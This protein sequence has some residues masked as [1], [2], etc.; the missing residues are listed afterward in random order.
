ML[1]AFDYP[2]FDF[3][4]C[5]DM[6][7][8]TPV[9]HPV[10]IVG[11]GPVGMAAAMDFAARGRKVL[12]L[13]DDKTVSVGS[14]AICFAKRTL[15]IMD[16]LGVGDAL[17]DKGIVWKI[18]KVFFGTDQ[19]YQFDLLPEDGHRMPAFI[20]LQQYHFEKAETDWLHAHPNVEIRWQNR[21]TNVTDHGHEVLVDIETPAGPYRIRADWVLAADG[22]RSAIRKM[23]DLDFHG[24]VFKDRFLIAD[25][26]MKADFP[27]ERWFWF[28]PP[29]NPGQSALL[30]MQADNVWRIDLQLGWDA[31]PEAE[32]QPGRVIPRLKRMLG[33]EVE[34]ELEWV[35]VYTFQ[36][37]RLDRFRHGRVLFVGDAAHQVSPF[38]ARGANSGIQDADNLVWKLDLVMQGVAGEA[39]LDSYDVERVIA[40]DENILNSTRS[41][42]F[43]TPK[44][45]ISRLF[46]DAALELAREHAFARR[47]VN[48][49]RLSVPCV[50]QDSPLNTPD[51]PDDGFAGPMQPGAPCADAPARGPDG[52]D[53]W[54]L[55]HLGGDFTLLAFDADLPV[56]AVTNL[57]V[58]VNILRIGVDL[59]DPTGS[60]ARRYDLRPGTV[61]LIRPDQHVAARSRRFDRAWLDGALA[62]AL[63]RMS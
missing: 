4:A 63:G 33:E 57:P 10:V 6:Q 17:L 36:C 51:N 25:V 19:V 55:H 40:A 49:G 43:I 52:G 59:F 34:F 14:R 15:E 24:Q 47:I 30:H 48:S 46:R 8:D 42:D 29:F 2:Q 39:L 3:R 32:K 61:Y 21:V 27:T 9:H 1:Q 35:S 62:R 22:A 60:I 45:P 54:L 44:S 16:R 58:P 56:D 53:D 37:R 12:V 20:N 5:P 23:L 31:D 41:T 7:A 50:L 18:G 11:A 28:D 13:D 38:G 26:V